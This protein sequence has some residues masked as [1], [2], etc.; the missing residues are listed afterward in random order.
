MDVYRV[1]CLLYALVSDLLSHLVWVEMCNIVDN[2]H[3]NVLLF[4]FAGAPV[5]TCTSVS[6]K[7]PIIA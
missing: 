3:S 5:E 4:Q 6:G 1:L 2:L 7:V